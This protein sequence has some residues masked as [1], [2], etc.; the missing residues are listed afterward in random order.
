M[1]I[2]FDWW[3][4]SWVSHNIKQTFYPSVWSQK[5]AF[6][7]RILSSSNNILHIHFWVFLKLSKKLW[8]RKSDDFDKYK[9]M[10]FNYKVFHM[11]Y[12]W[13]LGI[14]FIQLSK[15]IGNSLLISHPWWCILLKAR[16]KQ[17]LSH[18]ILSMLTKYICSTGLV[19]LLSFQHLTFYRLIL[20]QQTLER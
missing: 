7:H 6:E 12:L 20:Q 3:K 11:S 9:T 5:K 18:Q 13:M 16:P 1:R 15:W 17:W 14:L 8:Q 19:L 10:E 4:G 2:I